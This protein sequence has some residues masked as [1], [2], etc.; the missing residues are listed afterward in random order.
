M[1]N[2]FVGFINYGVLSAE[3]VNVWTA[4]SAHAYAAVSEK[5][6]ITVPNGWELGQNEFGSLIITSPWGWTYGPNDLLRGNDTPY[7]AGVDKSGQNF[8]VKLDWERLSD[9]Q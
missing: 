5:V 7:F 6:I 8:M 3:K 4:L 1:K 2:T 9:R